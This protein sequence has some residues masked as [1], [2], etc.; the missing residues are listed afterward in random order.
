[1]FFSV[2]VHYMYFA[3]I[4]FNSTLFVAVVI[5]LVSMP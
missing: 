4:L 2:K 5:S 1:M 3:A